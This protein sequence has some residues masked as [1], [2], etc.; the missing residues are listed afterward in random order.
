VCVIALNVA[1]DARVI[2]VPVK[3]L[4][5]S[6]GLLLDTGSEAR[7]PIAAGMLRELKLAPRSGAVLVQSGVQSER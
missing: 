2:D 3:A 7:W 4:G 5:V 6:E 1:S